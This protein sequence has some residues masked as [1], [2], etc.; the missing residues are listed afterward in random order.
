MG[1]LKF[2]VNEKSFGTWCILNKSSSVGRGLRTDMI[3]Y[4]LEHYIV[5]C[6]GDEQV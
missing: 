3:R 4:K 6:F 1:I 2:I 5:R